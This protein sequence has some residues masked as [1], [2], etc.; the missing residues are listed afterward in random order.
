MKVLVTGG[1]GFIGRWVVKKLLDNEDFDVHV[2]DNLSNGDKGNLEF[3]RKLNLSVCDIR[4]K[5]LLSELF[6]NDFDLCIHLAAQVNVQKSIDDSAE[7]L[8]V[9]VIGTHNLLEESRKHEVKFILV[10]TC[11]VYDAYKDMR[12]IAEIDSVLPKSPY[13]AS[14]HAAESLVQAYYHAYGLPIVIIRPFNVYGPFQKSS[15]EGGVISIFLNNKLANKKIHIFGDGLQSRDFLYV[16]DCA[17]F[18]VQASLSPKTV[19]ETFNIGSGKEVSI[20]ELA[21]K[22]I[23]DQRK[24]FMWSILTLKAKSKE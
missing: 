8:D 22:I 3:E 9:N 4:D 21:Y 17:D 16:E 19:G 15:S 23:Q 13:A 5:K 10:S 7:T 14:K 12:S 20:N 11:M 18:I 1:A 6:Q 2:L 24:L